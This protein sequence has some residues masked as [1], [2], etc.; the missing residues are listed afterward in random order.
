MPASGGQAL[1]SQ[2]RLYEITGAEESG[3]WSGGSPAPD[4]KVQ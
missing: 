3:A 2:Q 1:R 4:T